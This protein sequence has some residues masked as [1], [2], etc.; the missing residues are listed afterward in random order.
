MDVSLISSFYRSAEHLPVF[1]KRARALAAEAT[2]AGLRIEFVI[3]AND[4]QPDER[5]HIDTFAADVP[6]VNVLYVGRESLYASWNRGVAASAGQVIGFWN[7]DDARTS[8]AIVDGVARIRGG[9]DIVY[10]AYEIHHP[11]NPVRVFAA[12]PSDSGGHRRRMEAGPFF[13]FRRELEARIGPF[14]ANFRVVG[15]W[16]WIVRALDKAKFCHSTVIAG[17]FYIH[18]GNLSNTGSD[19]E[20]AEVN[21]VRLLH[22]IGGLTPAPPETMRSVWSAWAADHPLPAHVERQL[23]GD[24]AQAAWEAWR[25]GANARREAALRSERARRLP[26]RIIDA[27][28]LRPLLARL[29]LVKA[30]PK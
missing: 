27:L 16:E 10:F 21:V 28:G 1:F 8:A 20:S 11:P 22:G 7:A 26:K 29:G 19:R 14:D 23:W 17:A 30:R 3:V 13:L 15:D 9:C 2:A 6:D 18:G 25:D 4:A 5:M 12:M 24:G